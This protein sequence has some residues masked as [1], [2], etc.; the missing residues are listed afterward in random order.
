MCVEHRIV[1]KCGR[2]SA[3]FN[4]RDEVMPVEVIDRLYC[5]ECSDTVSFSGE[6]MLRDN[7]WIIEYDMEVAKFAGRTLAGSEIT[8]AFL[9][10]EGYCCWRGIYPQDLEDS[11]NERRQLV[12]LSKISPAQYIEEFRQWGVRRMERLQAEGW[13]KAG[14]R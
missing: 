8:P 12:S 5:P 3:S 7:G 13:R 14:A 10:D 4:F 1:C 9:F 6:R 11:L 2:N